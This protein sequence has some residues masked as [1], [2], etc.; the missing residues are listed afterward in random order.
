MTRQ[1]AYKILTKYLTNQVLLKHSLATEAVM[2]AIAPYFN[3]DVEEWGITGLLHDADYDKSKGHPQ[4]HGLL[5]FKLEPNSIPSNIEH[6]INA[7]NYEFTKIEPESKL[8]WALLICDELTAIIQDMATSK[9]K[10]LSDV[11]VD[12]I[13][14]KIQ[15][16]PDKTKQKDILRCEEKLGIKIEKLIVIALSSMEEVVNDLDL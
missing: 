12:L 9:N 2:R 11:G 15:N 10:K 1:T 14:S 13:F 7:H 4:K 16:F 6:A 5:L 3:E 8:D